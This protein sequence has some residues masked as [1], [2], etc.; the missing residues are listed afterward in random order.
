MSH[1]SGFESLPDMSRNSTILLDA[2]CSKLK[3]PV[4]GITLD[5]GPIPD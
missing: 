2:I 1:F 3:G 4:E 5:T